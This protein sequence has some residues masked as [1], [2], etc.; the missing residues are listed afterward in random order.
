MTSAPGYSRRKVGRGSFEISMLEAG[1]K[2]GLTY[3]QGP[4]LN[5]ANLVAPSSLMEVT[6]SSWPIEHAT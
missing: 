4:V 1:L 6:N 5:T 3:Y 2:R